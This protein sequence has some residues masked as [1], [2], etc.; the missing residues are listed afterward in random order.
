MELP[1]ACSLTASER[2][3]REGAIRSLLSG[4]E[5]VRELPGG[6]KLKFDDSSQWL[7]RIAE[8]AAAERDCCRF[9]RFEVTAE[10]DLGPIRLTITGPTGTAAF[11]R[12]GVDP[13]W[14][15]LPE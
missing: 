9:L 4:A 2:S 3:A 11:L 12:T 6:M 15:T 14:W 7:C 10:P 5:E 1:I 8:F 13:V